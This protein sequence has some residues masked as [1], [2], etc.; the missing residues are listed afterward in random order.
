M[1]DNNALSAAMA[2]LDSLSGL[3]GPKAEIKKIVAMQQMMEQRARAGLPTFSLQQKNMVFLGNPGTGKSLFA[4]HV[5]E[6]YRAL[7]IL[8]GGHVVECDRSELVAGY[9][10]QTAGK[11][12]KMIEKA[13]GGILFIDGADNLYS[14][15]PRDFGIEALDTIDREIYDP[16]V[17][18]A[19]VFAGYDR[20]ITDFLNAHPGFGVR[21]QLHIRFDDLTPDILYGIFASRLEKCSVGITS[22]AEDAVKRHFARVCEGKDERFGNARVAQIYLEQVFTKCAK[23]IMDTLGPSGAGTLNI[24]LADIPEDK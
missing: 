14:G 11:T 20:P 1:I 8:S 4:R 7:G 16:N 10:G 22:E 17:D 13:R 19:V 5:G 23:R 9:I 15:N 21:F 6:I 12:Q 18:L 2:A 24:T 3:E